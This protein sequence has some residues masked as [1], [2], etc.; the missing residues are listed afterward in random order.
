[1][2][3]RAFVSLSGGGDHQFFWVAPE[4]LAWIERSE[5]FERSSMYV[6]LP[7]DVVEAIRPEVAG[8]PY[9]EEAFEKALNDGINVT[10]GSCDN[11]KALA[12][13][14]FVSSYGSRKEALAAAN[15]NGW[16]ED[17]EY[18]GCIY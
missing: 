10:I 16:E 4:V 1:M 9:R 6:R 11:D 2:S 14:T 17:G 5:G 13:A 3:I 7:P 8:D 12:I 18:D 15:A